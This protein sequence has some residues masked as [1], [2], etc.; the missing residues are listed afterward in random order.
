M[1]Y[2]EA[3]FLYLAYFHNIYKKQNR[4]TTDHFIKRRILLIIF[5]TRNKTLICSNIY[6]IFLYHRILLKNIN[7]YKK[8][9][10]QAYL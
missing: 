1:L 9:F 10:I 8:L 5:F 3:E 2:K 6:L 4:Q 7:I